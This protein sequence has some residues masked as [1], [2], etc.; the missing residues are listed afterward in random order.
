MDNASTDATARIAQS[1]A[2]KDSRVRYY[3]SEEFVGPFD[4]WNRAFKKIDTTRS[5]YFMW[6]SDD[7]IWSVDYV[8]RLLRPLIEDQKCVL[9]FANF[10]QI[11]VLGA[12]NK[13]Y[14]YNFVSSDWK[15]K[16]VLNT[17]RWLMRHQGG[18]CAAYGVI[19]LDALSWFP[20]FPDTFFG[21]YGADL[22]F[23]L[24]LATK[25]RFAY[26][27]ELLFEK[28]V[29]G[30]SK[31]EEIEHIVKNVIRGIGKEQWEMTNELAIPFYVKLYIYFRL[32]VT[33]KLL[34]PSKSIELYLWPWFA[35]EMLRVNKR[36]LGVRSKLRVYFKMLLSRSV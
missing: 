12:I 13:E 27:N 1:Y 15:S 33:A 7:D 22:W 16:S 8:E 4:N 5:E 19:R 34:V 6:A 20:I 28:R 2:S 17:Y 11:D 36:G 18:H 25:G 32:K 29:G 23:L 31:Q 26:S 14:R 3:R 35:F 30:I 24:Q 10:M 21:R 9:S